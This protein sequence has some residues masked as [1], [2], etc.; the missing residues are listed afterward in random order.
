MLF[1]NID[2]LLMQNMTFAHTAGFSVQT[3]E[4]NG[5]EIENIEPYI[6]EIKFENINNDNH[7]TASGTFGCIKRR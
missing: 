6:K 7:S 5:H 4:I 2:N 1:N 3:G